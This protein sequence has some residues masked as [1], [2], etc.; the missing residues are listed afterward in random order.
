[1]N[2]SF[3]FLKE[4]FKIVSQKDNFIDNVLW[5]ILDESDAPF[6][7]Q[8]LLYESFGSNQKNTSSLIDGLQSIG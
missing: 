8:Q 6:F 3:T 5:P 1:M 7:L 4:I 2:R